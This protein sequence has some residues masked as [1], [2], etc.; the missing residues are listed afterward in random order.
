MWLVNEELKVLR[1]VNLAYGEGYT[2]LM[3]PGQ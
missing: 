3:E 2:A 1:H